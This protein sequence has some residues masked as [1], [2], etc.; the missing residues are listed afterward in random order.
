ME[1][2]YNTKFLL[3]KGTAE[4]WEYNNPILSQGEPGYDYTNYGLKIG[5]GKTEWKNLKFLNLSKEDVKKIVKEYFQENTI[6]GLT[7]INGILT[8]TL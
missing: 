2:V 4:A 5:D 6:G 7:V 8:F 3:R 1:V